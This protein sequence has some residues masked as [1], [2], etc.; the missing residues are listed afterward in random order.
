MSRLF[1][2]SYP[3]VLLTCYSLTR[4]TNKLVS[5]MF[6]FAPTLVCNLTHDFEKK[7][8]LRAKKTS[9]SYPYKR[10]MLV[11]QPQFLK[12]LRILHYSFYDTFDSCS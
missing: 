12:M 3:T 7:Q 2:L 1:V 4:V 8:T 11:W 10:K 6:Q 5:Y 9:N